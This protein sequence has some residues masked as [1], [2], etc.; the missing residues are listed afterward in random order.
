MAKKQISED[1]DERADELLAIPEVR[2]F[3]IELG[4]M[5]NEKSKKT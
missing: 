1:F 4:K 5:S 3:I 2:D